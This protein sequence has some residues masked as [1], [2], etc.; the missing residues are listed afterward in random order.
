MKV[1]VEGGR[2]REVWTD[3]SVSGDCEMRPGC[4]RTLVVQRGKRL[5]GFYYSTDVYKNEENK[6]MEVTKS[7]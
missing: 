3:L 4:I 5:S 7:H 6:S 2:E 1:E